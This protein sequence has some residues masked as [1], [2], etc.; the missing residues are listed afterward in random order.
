M[1]YHNPA[2]KTPH[3]DSLAKEG[4][5][6]EQNYAIAACTPSRAALLTGMYP[7][8]IGRQVTSIH[9]FQRQPSESLI[10]KNPNTQQFVYLPHSLAGLTL[11][12]KILPEYL[13]ELGYKTHIVGK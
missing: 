1:G 7:H 8:H 4:V 11:E 13:K 2:I 6:L 10:K 5:T 9:I 12:T 3:L